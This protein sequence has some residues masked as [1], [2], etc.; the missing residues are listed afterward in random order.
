MKEIAEKRNINICHKGHVDG[1]F[2]VGSFYI[3]EIDLENKTIFEFHR[4]MHH[5][6]P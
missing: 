3:D 5:A 1:E 4:C 6:C 2:K